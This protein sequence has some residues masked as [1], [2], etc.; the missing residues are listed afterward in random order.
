MNR[1]LSGGRR[2]TGWAALAA[3]LA[4]LVAGALLL[5]EPVTP[6]DVGTVPAA[7]NAGPVPL[8]VPVPV[9]A[10]APPVVP[11]VPSRVI[12]ATH[13]ISAAVDVVAA[14]SS[15]A[16]TIPEDPERLGWWIGSAMPGDGRGTVLIAGHVDTAAAGR[17]ALFKLETVAMGT[18]I[19]VR[20]GDH[21]V[22]YRA[23]ARR[24]YPKRHLPADLFRADGAPRLVLVTC[25]GAFR[26]GGY[27][28]NVVL[29]AVPLSRST[30]RS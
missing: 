8:P 18:R 28:H 15:G 5:R 13:R 25:G 7:A 19:D 23:M 17:G 11:A 24:S 3:G 6:P 12:I 27:T 16:L 10:A 14:G 4:A 21:D 22:T 1:R 29:Y 30:S 20:A 9:R 2:V 26:H